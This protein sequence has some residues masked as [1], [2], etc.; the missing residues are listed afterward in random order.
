MKSTVSS[1]VPLAASPQIRSRVIARNAVLNLAGQ[2][3]PLVVAVLAIPTIVNGL[4]V[5]RFGLFSMVWIIVGYFGMFDLGLGRATVKLVSEALGRGEAG[6]IP[7]VVWTSL[8]FVTPL[9]AAAAIL[10]VAVTP[11]LVGRVLSIPPHLVLEA[12]RVF[13]LSSLLIPITLITATLSGVLEAFQRFDL[14]NALRVPSNILT[15][16]IPAVGV[17]VGANLPLILAALVLKNL[18]V[19]LLFASICV[20]VVPGMRTLPRLDRTVSRSLVAFGAWVGLH[21]VAVVTLLSLDRFLV[22]VFLTMSAVTYYVAPYELVSRTLIVPSSLITVLFPAFSFFEA[23]DQGKLHA[24]FVRAFRYLALIMS[25]ML[26]VV[27]IFSREILTLWLGPEFSRS[28]VVL[29]ILSVGVLLSSLAWLSGT[30]LQ[31][32]NQPRLAALIHVFQVPVYVLTTWLLIR[33]LGIEGAAL[34]WTLR[35]AL[36]L[37]LL[38][39]AAWKS[40]WFRPAVL[41]Q[42]GTLT[43]TYLL[44]AAVGMAWWLKDYFHPAPPQLALV[45]G[46]SM[47]VVLTVIWKF[48]LDPNDRSF[49]L[50][51][52]N[53]LSGR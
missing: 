37:V 1:T 47:L 43:W 34:S 22:G 19:L 10:L 48:A 13:K 46:V 20:R 29:Q 32:V 6:R 44:A 2:T 4:G 45:F 28:T 39:G 11:T 38:L 21:N 41:A 12:D 35:I 53:V 15:Y 27:F 5:E 8:A 49:I 42:N 40:G 9:S 36:S 26:G 24:L 17:L 18:A 52:V 25:L 31:G 16:V 7:A 3:V 30:L 33:T 23:A 51:A 14:I 50:R